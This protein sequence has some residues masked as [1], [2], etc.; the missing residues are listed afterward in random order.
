MN[1]SVGIVGLPNA[2]KS[3]LFNALLRK[4]AAEAANYPFCTI[5]PNTGIVNVPDERLAPLAQTVHTQRI[6]P[7]SVEFVDIAGLVQGAHKGEG[8][9]N[10]FLSH[11]RET[12]AI[13]YVLRYF[14]D[15]DVV[16]VA[17]R[18]DPAG[19]LK[20]LEEEL[21]LADLQTLEKQREP[22]GAVSK[23]EKL[24]WETVIVLREGLNKGTAARD[25][26][27]TDDQKVHADSMFLLTAKPVIYV[28]NVSEEQLSQGIKED[29]Y[30]V[31]NA[32]LEAELI[33]ASDEERSELLASVGITEPALDKLITKAFDTLGLTTYLTAG[34]K[35]VRAW[36][37]QKGTLAPQ[38]AG[39]IHSDFEAKFIKAD[40]V[41]YSDFIELGGWAASRK[42]GKCRSEGKDYI[43][44]DGDVVEF[45][46]GA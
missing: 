28:A 29:N 5:E 34:E 3:T 19:D 23:E 16:H 22:K 8:L 6:I 32:K 45:K 31:L 12:S 37:I 33:D 35:E 20:I 14:E 13:C 21:L 10:Q 17:N 26:A 15:S 27:L 40:V 36:T 39:V 2:G 25:I 43:M 46:I 38:A 4:N 11:I 7:S 24:R 41:H 9:G 1:L 44:Q 42:A 18:V 30:I